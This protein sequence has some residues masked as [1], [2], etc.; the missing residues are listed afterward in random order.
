M[1]PRNQGI[2]IDPTLVERLIGTTPKTQGLGELIGQN[3]RPFTDDEF[4]GGF[5]SGGT[6]FDELKRG[7]A[8]L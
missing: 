1:A 4:F 3:V 6:K 8:T 2:M 7:I 5:G